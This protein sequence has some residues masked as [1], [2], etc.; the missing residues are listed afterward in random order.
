[1]K[2]I[3]LGLFCF[4][5]VFVFC[6]RC[7][8]GTTDISGAPGQATAWKPLK[9][10]AKVSSISFLMTPNVIWSIKNA[11]TTNARIVNKETLFTSSPGTV[12]VRASIENT[13][14][15]RDKF[16]KDFKIKVLPA[17]DEIH[18]LGTELAAHNDN[19]AETPVFL[20]ANLDLE[21]HWENLMDMLTVADRY[22]N[23]D[24][25]ES[26]GTKIPPLSSF[27]DADRPFFNYKVLSIIMPNSI[28]SIG[29]YAFYYYAGLQSINMGN[30]VAAIKDSAFYYC[31]KLTD[32]VIPDSVTSIGDSAFSRCSA[33]ASVSIGNNVSAIGNSAFSEC[34]NL[35][36]IVIPD[37]VTSIGDSAFSRCSALASANIGNNVS[38]IGNSVFFECSNLGSIIIPDSVTSI[39]NSVFNGC[40]SLAAIDAS[41]GNTMYSSIDGV[42][43][44]KTAA[45]LIRYPI[46]KTTAMYN[47]PNSV[48]SIENEAFRSCSK[49]TSVIMPGNVTNIGDSAFNGCVGLTTV[50]IPDNVT[51]IGDY[52]FNGCVGLTTVTIP[53]NVT[54]IGDY[55]F[56]NCR[57]LASIIVGNKVSAIGNSAFDGCSALISI[58]IPNSVTSIGGS[59]FNNC[60]NLPS[61]TIGKNIEFIGVYAFRNCS[62]LTS[63]TFEGAMTQT[64]VKDSA[65]PGDLRFRY[66]A[67]SGGP[68][69]YT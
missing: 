11:G 41:P 26:T 13:V 7:Y 59:A 19:T 35:G 33:L 39:G 24:L 55:A 50:T 40:N 17:P 1:M 60:D 52:A 3:T 23:L 8:F 32:I 15:I 5:A 10:E 53:D 34:S 66:F 30:N 58:T 48:S 62:N 57:G 49:L 67:T 31:D 21:I 2:K 56:S 12:V 44:N 42:L 4:V 36:S 65:F 45:S 46:G 38:A 54:N 16:S 68:G 69:T 64:D 61:V 18:I 28:T 9:L 47:I 14:N 27:W 29:S 43:Y 25:T 63:V 22:V 37:S 20:K 51:N 6:T